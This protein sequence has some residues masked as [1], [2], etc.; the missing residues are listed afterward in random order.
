MRDKHYVRSLRSRPTQYISQSALLL[1][2][3]HRLC[4]CHL[5]PHHT[6]F[7]TSPD[8]LSHDAPRHA[9]AHRM[10]AGACVEREQYKHMFR[11]CCVSLVAKRIQP[12]PAGRCLLSHP[13]AGRGY[14]R[15]MQERSL[16]AC[17]LSTHR[18]RCHEPTNSPRQNAVQ[19]CKAE[20]TTGSC[21]SNARPPTSSASSRCPPSPPASLP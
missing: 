12:L 1:S 20:P 10:C 18:A 4:D 7:R 16:R 19:T 13:K 5:Y 9:C 11:Y 8:A 14:T 3:S 21:P 15:S 17:N 2:P 6:P